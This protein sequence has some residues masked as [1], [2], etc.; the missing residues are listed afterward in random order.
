MSQFDENLIKNQKDLGI[1]FLPYLNLGVAKDAA[2]SMLALDLSVLTTSDM[3]VLPGVTSRN[4]V[5]ILKQGSGFD[6]DAAYHKFGINYS[7]NLA[8][9]PKARRRR[10]AGWSSWRWSSS[11]AS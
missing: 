11:S 4:S 10:C 5:V 6:G 9:A 8:Q 1:G 7:M 3:A 2:S